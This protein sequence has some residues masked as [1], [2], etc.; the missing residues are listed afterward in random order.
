MASEYGLRPDE[1]VEDDPLTNLYIKM[2]TTNEI[3]LLFDDLSA[4]EEIAQTDLQLFAKANNDCD[5]VAYS[6][7][8]NRVQIDSEEIAWIAD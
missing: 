4:L 2:M 5:C 3:D 1:Q 8:L 6:S 7:T